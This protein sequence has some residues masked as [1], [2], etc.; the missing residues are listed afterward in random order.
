MSK[1][2]MQKAKIVE[3]TY[4]DGNITVKDLH[5][6]KNGTKVVVIFDITKE[7]LARELASRVINESEK[8]TLK[9]SDKEMETLSDTLDI[10]KSIKPKAEPKPFRII[11]NGFFAMTPENLGEISEEDLDKILAD[12][13]IG[14]HK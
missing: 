9:I 12:E 4:R 5:G 2:E 10:T 3:G 6:I 11:E 8:T 14:R 1:P 13:A 7:E